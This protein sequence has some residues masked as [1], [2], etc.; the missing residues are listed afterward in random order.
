M[1]PPREHGGMASEASE[2]RSGPSASMGPPRE[3]GGMHRAPGP[4][5]NRNR[6]LQWGRRVNTAECSVGVDARWVEHLLQWGRRVNTAE[7]LPVVN[8]SANVMAA[9]MGPPRE[10]GGMRSTK[11]PM[12]A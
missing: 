6:Q 8:V 5:P 9:S 4:V 12:K 7:C 2:R 11:K 10:H 1:G 3:H